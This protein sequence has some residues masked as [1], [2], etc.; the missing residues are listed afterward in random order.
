MLQ[1]VACAALKEAGEKHV[2]K[3]SLADMATVVLSG[4]IICRPSYLSFCLSISKV[5]VRRVALPTETLL[6]H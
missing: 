5:T 6:R 1:E 4:S 2:S 3:S